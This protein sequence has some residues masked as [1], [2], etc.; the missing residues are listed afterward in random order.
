MK[1]LLLA[2]L[3]SSLA[4]AQSLLHPMCADHA[5]LQRGQPIRIYG[6]VRPGTE[7]KVQMGNAA[8]TT[9]AGAGGQ[10][11]ADLPAMPAGGPYS[12]Q[13]SGGGESQQVSDVLVGDVFLCTG[14]SNM[15]LSVRRAANAE[16][17]IAAA[18]D[19][20]VRELAI[21][22]IASPETLTRFSTPVAWKVESPQTAG[23]FSASCFYFARELRK[24][25]K[26]PIGLVTAAW[27]GTRDRGWVSEASLRALGFYNDDLDMLALYRRDPDAASHRWD[28]AWQ[29]WWR[30]HARGEPRK[31]ETSAWLV[32]PQ[33]L[34]AWNDWPGLS[35]PDGSAEPGVGFVGQVWL[36][37]HVSLTA[38]QAAQAATLELGRANA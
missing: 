6:Q 18:T 26:V 35:L 32:A 10:W 1:F 4:A 11:S 30:S 8:A 21:E 16:A 12:L 3:L 9:R 27:G 2:L 23:D 22:R 15:Q 17:E 38:A 29:A 25:V 36:S 20:E 5:V 14:Q 33:G 28:A 19:A 37:T 7:V 13:V 34:G 31:A 24:A